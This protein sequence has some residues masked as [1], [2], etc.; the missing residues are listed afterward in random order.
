[1]TGLEGHVAHHHLGGVGQ[2]GLLR[3]RG[4]CACLLL[5]GV[6]Q[7]AGMVQKRV[8]CCAPDRADGLG[9]G[10]SKMAST[11]KA[12]THGGHRQS[13]K[14]LA[15]RSR[16]AWQRVRTFSLPPLA[17]SPAAPAAVLWVDSCS[18]SLCPSSVEPCRRERQCMHGVIEVAQQVN[19][20]S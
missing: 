2:L 5:V 3:A 14:Q 4:P 7:R 13:V 1:M 15:A 6:V 8:W 11:S 9:R 17:A 16:P 18:A 12:T 19:E 10:W 20:G